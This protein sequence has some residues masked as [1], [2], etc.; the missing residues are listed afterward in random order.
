MINQKE[1]I[2]IAVDE[3]FINSAYKQ[4]EKLPYPSEF[5]ILTKDN[6]S[7]LK[8]VK[9]HPNIF[10]LYPNRK[11]L[12]KFANNI[13]GKIIFFHGLNFYSAFLVNPLKKNSGNILIWTLWGAE[14]YF[15]KTLF[16]NQKEIYLGEIS[17]KLQKK[18]QK[19]K[20][21]SNLKKNLKRNLVFLYNRKPFLSKSIYQSMK[22]MDCIAI[23]YEEEKELIANKLKI[24]YKFLKF[25]YYPLELMLSSLNDRVNN[26]DILIGNSAS[27]SN[28]HL[29]V[30]EK[31]NSLNLK[32]SNIYCPLSYGDNIYAK[33]ILRKGEF[34]FKDKFKPLLKF[35]EVKEY[36]TILKSCGIVIMNHYRQQAVGNVMT[37]LYLGAKVY[38]NKKNT[39]YHY[40]K[41][42]NVII[43][44]VEDELNAENKDAFKN[45]SI[46]EQNHN[47]KIIFEE[48]NIN[49]LNN[50]LHAGIKKCN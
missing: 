18:N 40:L 13:Y 31:L 43:F 38:L 24:D 14:F 36:N 19:G 11:N 25:S 32:E 48:L 6:L 10:T 27:L 33:E 35:M 7:E 44:S 49:S 21:F 17:K 30:F 47:R 26:N 2:H 9:S 12:I 45:L 39:L 4:F 50:H 3:K 28:N 42:I 41:R 5:Y 22:K 34:F 8:Y 37:M 23:L 29:E 16:K 1:I 15:N 20:F 46:D